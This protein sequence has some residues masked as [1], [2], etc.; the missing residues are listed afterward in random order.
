MSCVV[1]YGLPY[2]QI[3]FFSLFLL[4]MILILISTWFDC[5]IGVYAA[6]EESTGRCPVCRKVFHAKDIDH[7]LGLVGAHSQLVSHCCS[8]FLL[9][10]FSLRPSELVA[11]FKI[12]VKLK[13]VWRW[14]TPHSFPKLVSFVSCT[15]YC[16]KLL[17]FYLPYLLCALFLFSSSTQYQ[18]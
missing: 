1:N 6:A 14:S 18:F 13:G 8:N 2:N 4:S 9:W 15:L 7:V 5:C 10:S 16:L 11:Q 12:L 17:P 3:L